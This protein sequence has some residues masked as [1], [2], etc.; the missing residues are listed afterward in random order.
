MMQHQRN[1]KNEKP[2]ADIFMALSKGIQAIRKEDLY[3]FSDLSDEN[4]TS[5]KTIW[6]QVNEETR[7][8]L[9][10]GL[11][12]LSH[13]D[14]LVDFSMMG[15][16][17]LNDID[18]AVRSYA[19]G[20]MVECRR[21]SF[22]KKV[23][24]IA[25]NDPDTDVRQSAIEILG[26]FVIDIEME[27]IPEKEG[28]KILTALEALNQDPDERIRLRVME[29]L[30]YMDHPLVSDLMRS[31]LVSTK[32]ENV[33]A[34]LR[35]VQ[36]SLNKKWAGKIIDFIDHPNPNVQVEAIKAAGLIQSQKTVKPILRLLTNF[37]ELENDVLDAAILAISQIGGNQVREVIEELEEVFA[38]ETDMMDLFDEA[39]DNLD[40]CEFSQKNF[41]KPEFQPFLESEESVEDAEDDDGSDEED[42]LVLIRQRIEDL[43]Q[44]LDD[45]E[46]ENSTSN[47]HLHD[48][49]DHDLDWAHFRIIE[50]LSKESNLI[51]EEDGWVDDESDEE[52]Q[53]F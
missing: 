52:S 40:L 18:P 6:P 15:D 38:N 28:K 27:D 37:D 23:I 8:S 24:D 29:S 11:Y 26:Q 25:R 46:D 19:L 30:A 9:F 35:A 42:Y 32:E 3:R 7:E 44:R 45:E 34:G 17:G 4:L 13:D 47:I 2:I 50:D 12:L 5:L 51:D 1:K 31:A 21:S 22:L 49:N 33:I 48:E 10:E 14:M 43:P 20:L 53:L 41:N 36:H 16:F 39:R